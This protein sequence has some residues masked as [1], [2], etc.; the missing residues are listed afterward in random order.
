[1]DEKISRPRGKGAALE[2]YV[3][4]NRTPSFIGRSPNEEKA[5]GRLSPRGTDRPVPPVIL[6]LVK[7]PA[8]PVVWFVFFKGARRPAVLRTAAILAFKR[9][10]IA[11]L[12]QCGLLLES[13]SAEAWRGALKEAVGALWTIPLPGEG[14]KHHPVSEAARRRDNVVPLRRARRAQASN[15]VPFR[16]RR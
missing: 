15:I 16:R 10:Q 12:A 11:A 1:M 6:R 7:Y 8:E 13:V 5:P 2:R 3:Q 14:V 9:V 4:W